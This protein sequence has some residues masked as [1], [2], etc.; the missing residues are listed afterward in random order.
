VPKSLSHDE[1][2]NSFQKCIL[3]LDRISKTVLI[4]PFVVATNGN[5]FVCHS[6]RQEVCLRQVRDHMHIYFH[7]FSTGF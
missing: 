5:V 6:P 4:S 2:R 7:A 3:L 1:N